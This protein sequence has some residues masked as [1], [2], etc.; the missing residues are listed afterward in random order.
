M[1]T[2]AYVSAADYTGELDMWKSVGPELMHRWHPAPECTRF[3]HLSSLLLKPT[4]LHGYRAHEHAQPPPVDASPQVSVGERRWLVLKRPV[5]YEEETEEERR[6]SV[7][8]RPRRD[9]NG[10][11]ETEVTVTSEQQAKAERAKR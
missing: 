5:G 2:F 7:L 1:S 6:W 4:H 9:I 11:R 3:E 10:G 8:E